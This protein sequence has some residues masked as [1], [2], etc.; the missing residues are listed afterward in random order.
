MSM[1]R[2]LLGSEESNGGANMTVLDHS[3]PDALVADLYKHKGKE[4]CFTD[5]AG[6]STRSWKL[7][8]ATV[9]PAGPPPR[10]IKNYGV[11]IQ[12]R[13][14]IV[15]HN[16]L[17]DFSFRLEAGWLETPSGAE[18]IALCDPPSC[19]SGTAVSQIDKNLRGAFS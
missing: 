10:F 13:Y 14:N 6:N 17:L 9:V 12:Y 19:A 3:S 8:S 16:H 2:P 1:F 5:S 18:V 11:K 15:C 7:E 4:C